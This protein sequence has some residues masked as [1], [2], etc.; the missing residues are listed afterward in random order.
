MTS[1]QAGRGGLAPL[2]Q[3]ALPS[4]VFDRRLS[5]DYTV[6]GNRVKEPSGLCTFGLVQNHSRP[7]RGNI[8][9][10]QKQH[11]PLLLSKQF[12]S[13]HA[14]RKAPPAEGALRAL[15]NSLKQNLCL[16]GTV[17]IYPARES[18]FEGNE[19]KPKIS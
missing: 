10:L 19:G 4:Q 3:F 18:H 1:G 11:A 15:Q 9:A 2:G 14:S 13:M 7:G 8:E 16:A 6:V 17:Q 12:A 5:G